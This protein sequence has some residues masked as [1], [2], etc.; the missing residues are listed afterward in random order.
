MK[1]LRCEHVELDDCVV[2]AATEQ[3]VMKKAI[4]HMWEYHDIK[5]EEMTSVMK[6]KIK[7]KM[8]TF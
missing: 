3:D 2:E 8:L 1:Q 5:Q 4:E 7:E 6:M